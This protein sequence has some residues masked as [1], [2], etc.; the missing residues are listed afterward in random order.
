MLEIARHSI[1][2]TASWF[3][4][5]W[6]LAALVIVTPARGAQDISLA[7]DASTDTNVMGYAIYYSTNSGDWN[8][9]FDCGSNILATFSSLNM[10]TTYYFVVVAYDSSAMESLPSDEV[11]FTVPTNTTPALDPIFNQTVTVGQTLTITNTSTVTPGASTNLT[12]TLVSGP[13]GMELNP[14]NGVLTW[15]PSSAQAG[16]VNMATVLVSDDSVPPLTSWRTFTVTVADMV[17]L[18]VDSTVVGMGQTSTANVTVSS[19][20]PAT[21][22]SFTLDAPAGWVANL[23]V[24]S[25]FPQNVAVTQNPPGAA[26][27]VITVQTTDG[28]TLPNGQPLV[29]LSITA[30]ANQTTAATMLY[31]SAITT[32]LADGQTPLV[33]NAASSLIF[34]GS[35]SLLQLQVI[36]GQPSLTLY[37]Q[38]GNYQIQST[39]DLTS[40]N[41]TNESSTTLTGLSQT[42]PSTNSSGVTAKFFRASISQ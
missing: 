10:G 28:S 25:L 40:G 35:S 1:R 33:P 31:A 4:F 18:K 7:W 34:V 38:P 6:L 36:S 8:A 39:T 3:Q 14:T 37:G 41:W 27:S 2:K 22:L 17:Q 21:N 16:S 29:Q 5:L 23:S 13:A 30:V 20:S 12:Y 19:T 15:A 11:S 32:S 24:Q 9:R 26:H 42:I